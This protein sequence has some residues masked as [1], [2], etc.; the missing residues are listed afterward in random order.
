MAGPLRRVHRGDDLNIPAETFNTLIEMAREHSD[1]QRGNTRDAGGERRD[2]NVVLVRNESGSNRDRFD[3]LGVGGPLIARV[4]NEQEHSRQVALRG[5]VP[6]SPHAGRFV[7]LLEPAAP[8]AIVRAA[9]SGVCVARVE[10]VDENHPFA[11]VLVGDPSRLASSPSGR[12][13]MLWVEPPAE[14]VSPTLATCILLL[15]GGGGATSEYQALIIGYTENYRHWIGFLLNSQGEPTGP[16]EVIHAVN[17]RP[18][19][20]DLRT[21]APLIRPF[22]DAQSVVTV[23][24]QQRDVGQGREGVWIFDGSLWSTCAFE[25]S[26]EGQALLILYPSFIDLGGVVVGDTAGPEA[27]T[28][29]NLHDEDPADYTAALSAL[30]GTLPFAI[31]EGDEAGTVAAE[32]TVPIRVTFAP[33][34]KGHFA[35]VLSV[36]SGPLLLQSVVLGEGLLGE[37]LIDPSTWD[38]GFIN[39]PFG[40]QHKTIKVRNVGT[41]PITVT[42]GVAQNDD[43]MFT[44]PE[45]WEE[46]IPPGGSKDYVVTVTGVGGPGPGTYFG[47]VVFSA[48]HPD[49]ADAG[50]V[51]SVS[52]A[53][54]AALEILPVIIIE[55]AALIGHS[56]GVERGWHIRNIGESTATISSSD[57]HMSGKGALSITRT[58]LKDLPGGSQEVQDPLILEPGQTG[59]LSAVIDADPG[60][61]GEYGRWV[62]FTSGSLTYDRGWIHRVVMI[63]DPPP[64]EGPRPP[65]GGD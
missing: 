53:G 36:Q 49:V 29:E 5:V 41:A 38:F 63:I 43:G 35:A 47:N 59:V 8:N 2:G 31:V 1:R 33:T 10:M 17:K 40:A 45:S 22:E 65:P 48:D 18:W 25:L 61:P 26:P 11:D 24:F 58:M 56:V 14:R 37:L 15:G 12:A 32:D 20:A 21:C 34:E 51:V 52:I 6:T 55:S 7:V 54:D 30:R 50:L 39:P 46:T 23:K 27:F 9:V 13:R 3:I 64:P 44:F 60:G 16:F 4:E 28:L 19:S 62:R 42:A 57:F